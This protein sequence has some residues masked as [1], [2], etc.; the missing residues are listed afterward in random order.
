LNIQ[1]A[2]IPFLTAYDPS[3]LPGGSID[4]LGFERGYL[5]LADKI[6]PGLTNAAGRPRYFSIMCAGSI[7]APP[8]T[9]NERNNIRARAERVLLLERFWAAAN[10]FASEQNTQLSASGIRGVTYAQAYL[11]QLKDRGMRST[12]ADFKMLAQQER[13]GAIGIY[14]NVAGYLRLLNRAAMRP[15]QDLGEPLGEAFLKETGF[16]ARLRGI[17]RDGEGSIGIESLREW[18]HSAHIAAP[19]GRIEGEYLGEALVHDPIRFR[20]AELVKK[21]PPKTNEE[22]ELSRLGRMRKVASQRPEN[23]DL[24]EAIDAILA[25]EQCYRIVLLGFERVLWLCKADGSIT[26]ANVA[27]DHVVQWCAEAIAD[28]GQQFEQALSSGVTELFRR[29]LDRLNDVKGFVSGAAAVNQTQLFVEGLLDRHTDVQRGKFDRGR[30]KLPWIE[31][32]SSRYEL[33]LSQVGDVSG[34][35][36][37]VDTVRPH[38]YRLA[39]ADRFISA[40]LG[41]TA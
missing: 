36:K 30:R 35:P 16:P 2:L 9:D 1:P 28:V 31:R 15:T 40:S 25:F 18:G 3:D 29:D 8:G 11:E 22:T 19:V 27:R 10:V 21:T 13:Y 5:F 34:E 4:P 14:A 17:I 26:A 38:E 39:T 23:Q 41:K 6:L 12:N 32:K 20:M 7:L 24:R 33:T 37:S